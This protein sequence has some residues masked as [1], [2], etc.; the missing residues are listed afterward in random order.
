MTTEK[1]GKPGS[2]SPVTP[3]LPR[4]SPYQLPFPTFFERV[5][6]PLD[7]AVVRVCQRRTAGLIH[8][9]V[10]SLTFFTS[11]EAFLTA[12][13][14]LF[15][16]GYDA[17]AALSGSVLMVLGIVSQIPKKF[18]FRP[19][20]WMVSR[21]LA[22]R[23]DKT[24]SF[25]SRAV[26]CAVVFSWLIGWSL[27]L[28]GIVP[29]PLSSVKLWLGIIFVSALTAFARINVGA[30]YASDTLF[31]FVLGVLVI[32]LGSRVEELWRAA[33]C[34]VEDAYPNVPSAVMSDLSQIARVVSYSRLLAAIAIAYAMTLVSVQGF[35]VK[36]S[37]VYGLL[38]SAATF[39][40]VFL[41][42]GPAD[43]V[44]GVLRIVDHGD[45]KMHLKA[46][47]TF[48]AFLLFGML[49]RGRKGAFRIIAFTVIYF[50]ALFTVIHWR[51]RQ[52][53]NVH[54]EL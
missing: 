9:F 17:A 24:S 23:R 52:S 21:A 46:I 1:D 16:L 31:G 54:S 42:A 37:Y 28:E 22:V 6:A 50:G 33:G 45:A 47:S 32:K 19:R 10:M 29:S 26:V 36:C 7:D 14:T 8:V 44:G 41:C 15:A 13:A 34:S 40:S 43:A 48:A 4:P 3:E 53:P 12:P 18:I 27:A 20:P 35:W 25:P 30:H 38:F 39:R 2:D 5:L 51:L 49:T 11:I